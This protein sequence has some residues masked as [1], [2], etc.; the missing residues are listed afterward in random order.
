[1]RKYTP[2]RQRSADELR[3]QGE[4]YR[5]MAA[6]ART[7][8]AKSGLE[9]LAARLT[10]LAD[11]REAEEDRSCRQSPARELSSAAY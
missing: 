5:E 11:Q 6:T 2:L 4:L 7:P 3:T 9:R 1:M 10:V 8:V